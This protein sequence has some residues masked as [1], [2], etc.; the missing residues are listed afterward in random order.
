M[1]TS[2][3][4]RRVKKPEGEFIG[5]R[6]KTE[7]RQAALLSSKGMTGNN[8][9]PPYPKKLHFL[10][11]KVS[12]IFANV[13]NICV[14][15]ANYRGIPEGVSIEAH[16]RRCHHHKGMCAGIHGIVRSSNVISG[17]I[18]SSCANSKYCLVL[19]AD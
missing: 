11:M 18:D 7:L 14:E 6:N 19:K 2:Q 10:R 13:L 17:V 3:N 5:I 16:F 9:K 1:A 4:K 15:D 12:G 8:P